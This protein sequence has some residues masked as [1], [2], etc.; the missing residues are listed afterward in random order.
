MNNNA[1][2]SV[3]MPVYNGSAYVANALESLLTQSLPPQQVI[4]IDDGS[5]DNTKACV[6]NV[7]S[8]QIHYLQQSHEGP[9]A[10]RNAGIQQATGDILIFQDADDR[11]HPNRI[12]F[13]HQALME[14]SE[15]RLVFSSMVPFTSDT[16]ED[17]FSMVASTKLHAVSPGTLA[18][19]RSVWDDVGPFKTDN[20]L[21]SFLEW[22]ARAHDA[23]VHDYVISDPLVARR[24]HDKNHTNVDSKTLGSSY[25]QSLRE[26]LHRRKK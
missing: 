15:S 23:G 20:D 11:A 13:Q 4:V 16:T 17:L 12:A 8:P 19:K 14:S 9:W 1:S 5:T 26:V 7:N 22:Y 6:L 24:V 18:C 25:L 2:I 21:G 10:A 3:I